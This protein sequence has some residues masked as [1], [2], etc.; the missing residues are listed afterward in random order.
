MSQP[1]VHTAAEPSAISTPSFA[2]VDV[3]HNVAAI[4]LRLLLSLAI[5]VMAW[6]LARRFSQF[7]VK[8][9]WIKPLTGTRLNLLVTTG[10]MIMLG[11]LILGKLIA[12]LALPISAGA[13]LIGVLVLISMPLLSR[14]VLAG[15]TLGLRG[16]LAPGMR[17]KMLDH[18]GYIEKVGLS[19][20]TLLGDDGGRIV[21]PTR[22]LR[23][24]PYELRAADRIARLSFDVH[25]PVPLPKNPEVWLEKIRW[26]CLVCPY[27][28]P[29]SPITVT[30]EDTDVS[31]P[32]VQISFQVFSDN[33][34]GLA[35]AFMNHH[36]DA[37]W[38]EDVT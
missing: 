28:Q 16:Q 32:C 15:L 37:M 20:I 8:R 36:L 24:S 38:K 29:S 27:R 30:L 5:L 10:M 9:K 26:T 3:L 12:A 1:A 7:A 35:R 31:T 13:L 22:Q 6:L 25:P 4:D 14:D 17:L 19:S 11:W 21:M 34:S 18:D 33:A 23:Q 2:E